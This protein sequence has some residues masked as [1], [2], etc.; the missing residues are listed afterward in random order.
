VREAARWVDRAE[1]GDGDGA[2]PGAWEIFERG[3]GASGAKM[4]VKVGG[5]G[6][7]CRGRGGRGLLAWVCAWVWV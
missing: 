3:W 1:E 4:V 2:G 7:M 5:A 6:A